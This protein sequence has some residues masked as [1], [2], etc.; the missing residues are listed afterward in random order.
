MYNHA[1]TDYICPFCLLVHGVENE[2]VLTTQD[3]VVYR[4]DAVTAC[5][6]AHQF[7]NNHGNTLVIPNVHYENIYDLPAECR[8]PATG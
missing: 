2:R 5:I 4:D 7:V 8:T 1:P 3:D 6:S